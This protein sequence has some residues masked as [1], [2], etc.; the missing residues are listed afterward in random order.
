MELLRACSACLWSALQPAP[1]QCSGVV[2]VPT[3]FINTFTE[4]QI[5][6]LFFCYLYQLSLNSYF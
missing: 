2:I 5:P 3:L 6:L 1:F 4:L